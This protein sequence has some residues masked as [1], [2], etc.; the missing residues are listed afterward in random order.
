MNAVISRQVMVDAMS[1]DFNAETREN[2]PT[3]WHNVDTVV[4]EQGEVD[5]GGTLDFHLIEVCLHGHWR[6]RYDTELENDRQRTP[7]LLPNGLQYVPNDAA[8]HIEAEGRYTVQ[9]I[10]VDARVFRD[11]AGHFAQGDPD[12]VKPVGFQGIFDQQILAVTRCILEESRRPSGGGDLYADHLARK[13]AYLILERLNAPATRATRRRLLSAPELSR[14]AGHI[15]AH[16]ADTGGLETF[17]R[18]LD[19]DVFSFSRAFK[20]TTGMTPHQYLIDRRLTK[21]KELLL[22]SDATLAAIAVDTG[23][24][25][26]SHMNGAFLR[27]TSVSPGRWRREAVA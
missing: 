8:T 15:E 21:I 6:A 2:F 5:A 10:Y 7:V 26:Q 24:S 20:A 4:L 25:S 16:L 23:F 14:V 3:R 18:L 12:H 17:A 19:M 9:Q 1:A 22:H 13:L 11:V 27:A